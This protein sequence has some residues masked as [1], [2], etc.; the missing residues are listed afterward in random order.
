MQHYFS[1]VEM[2]NKTY[3]I[4]CRDQVNL[5]KSLNIASGKQNKY[6]IF[7]NV[8]AFTFEVDIYN[9]HF[10]IY[11]FILLGKQFSSFTQDTRIPG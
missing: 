11:F 2:Y 4:F 6:I 10:K 7:N 8:L 9:L 5:F 3:D 1:F